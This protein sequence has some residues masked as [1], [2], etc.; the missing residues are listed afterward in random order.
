MSWLVSV[1]ARSKSWWAGGVAGGIAGGLIYAITSFSLVGLGIFVGAIFGGL[2]LDYVVSKNYQRAAT[3]GEIPAWWAGG[4]WGSG[5]GGSS[6]GD[7]GGFGGGFGGGDF[8][9]GGAS[10]DW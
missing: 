10:G 7:G 3:T 5:F 4:T 2:L 6:G 8:G 1:F 9:G